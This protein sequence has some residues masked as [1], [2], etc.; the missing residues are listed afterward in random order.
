[1]IKLNGFRAFETGRDIYASIS[2]VKGQEE[3]HNAAALEYLANNEKEEDGLKML[4]V[5]NTIR[6]L[7]GS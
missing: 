7:G 3:F 1:M 4:E 6:K 5:A 2:R